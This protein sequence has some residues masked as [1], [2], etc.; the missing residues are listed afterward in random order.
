MEHATNA[1]VFCRVLV[2][3]RRHGGIDV[4]ADFIM[5][6]GSELMAQRIVR[7]AYPTAVKI[8]VIKVYG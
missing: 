6:A 1:D 8:E 7:L 4:I 2:T 5:P 3:D